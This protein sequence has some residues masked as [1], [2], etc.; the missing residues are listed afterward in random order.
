MGCSVADFDK[1]G[2]KDLYVTSF[3]GPNLLFKN[4]G[5]GTFLDI[6]SCLVRFEAI[7]LQAH[8]LDCRIT[9]GQSP[10]IRSLELR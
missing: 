9:K 7:S 2:F 5:Y 4:N 10:R 3:R 6:S 8:D 1:D